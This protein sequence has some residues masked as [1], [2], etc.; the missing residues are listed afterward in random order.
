MFFFIVQAVTGVLL[1]FYYRPGPDSYDSVRQITYDMNFGWLIR[2]VHSWGGQPDGVRGFHAH[3]L[4]LLHEGLPQAARIRLVERHPALLT[5]V[6]GFSGYL[7]PMDD[8]AYFATK[9]GLE[10]P[11]IA[12]GRRADLWPTSSAADR[13]SASHTVQRFFSLHVVL[14][15]ARLSPAAGVSPVARAEARQRPAAVGGSQAAAQ[16]AQ[17]FRSSRI[18]CSTTS[19]CG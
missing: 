6:F 4:R 17:R 8:L 16:R 18:S 15:P 2:S 13:K 3:V 19:P 9:V 1:L 12:A 10:I 7:L 11:V 14:L 5:M